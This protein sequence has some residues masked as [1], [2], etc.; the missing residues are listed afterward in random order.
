MRLIAALLVLACPA[1]AFG[2]TCGPAVPDPV[3]RDALRLNWNAVTTWVAPPGGNIPTP[4][5]VTYSVY[6]MVGTVAS[7]VCTTTALSAGITGLPVGEHCHAVTAKTPLSVPANTES[8]RSQTV[9]KTIEP[10]PLTPAAPG[11][12]TVTGAITVNLTV[13]PNP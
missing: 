10:Q 4:T 9:C 5:Q 1:F 2:Q 11:G 13:T 12:F 3:P 8:A 6:K 7:L